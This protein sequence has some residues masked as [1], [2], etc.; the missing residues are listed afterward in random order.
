MTL[1]VV[2]DMFGI[3]GR[4]QELAAQLAAA[5]R[6]ARGADGC[7]RYV[8]ASSLTE[9]DHYVVV[10]EWR[11]EAALQEHYASPAFARFQFALDGLLARLSD[12]TVHTVGASRRL[13]PSG[14]MDHRDAD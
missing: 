10:E 13:V 7:V 11:D 12:A 5:E 4:R 14:P 9:P 3:A 1:I 8:V 2:A 6:D